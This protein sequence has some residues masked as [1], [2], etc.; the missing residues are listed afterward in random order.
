MEISGSYIDCLANLKGFNSSQITLELLHLAAVMRAIN[1]SSDVHQRDRG[2]TWGDNRSVVRV[3]QWETTLITVLPLRDE[4]EAAPLLDIR[5]LRAARCE[6]LPSN[7]GESQ[8]TCFAM[9]MQ[10]SVTSPLP[11]A[12]SPASTRSGRAAK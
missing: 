11:F 12:T 6:S 7:D 1:A 5:L 4:R 3:F 8:I 9:C 2:R 10:V